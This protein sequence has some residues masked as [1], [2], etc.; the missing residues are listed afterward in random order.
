MKLYPALLSVACTML[1]LLRTG[2]AEESPAL[3]ALRKELTAT[4]LVL[5][6]YSADAEQ[7]YQ[8]ENGSLIVQQPHAHEFAFFELE[9]VELQTS[10]LVIKG[11]RRFVVFD[12]Q[13]HKLTPTVTGR[14][15]KLSVDLAKSNINDALPL[16]RTLLFK[17]SLSDAV[18]GVPDYMSKFVPAVWDAKAK[19]FA[20]CD[21]CSHGTPD[22]N[23][24]S[25]VTV[26]FKTQ[27]APG[28]KT[29][30]PPRL[31]WQ[32]A[33]E[34][35]D[36]AKKKALVT[37]VLIRIIVDTDGRPHDLW[38]VHAAGYGLDEEAI[39]A[40]SQYKFQPATGDNTPV[41]V[42]VNVD[43]NSRVF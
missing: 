31:V 36:E 2:Y 40:V 23:S 42:A 20:T 27:S 43:V 3:A 7:N 35:P 24:K 11:K 34:I 18:D 12:Q 26:D 25:L 16:M 39:K 15:M 37:S 28:Y 10:T 32:V 41:P 14:P 38:L 8:Y 21:P 4:P 9:T 5:S 17:L 6:D 1:L 33:P 13:T 30:K 19:T 29:V 22:Q